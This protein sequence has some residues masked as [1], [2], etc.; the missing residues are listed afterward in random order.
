MGVYN[1]P[2]KLVRQLEDNP[3]VNEF[4]SKHAYSP[5]TMFRFKTSDGVDIDGYMIR[6]F[7]FDST[8]TYPVVLTVYGGP[9]SHD[10]FNQF[11]V[12]GW[13]QW[14]AQN[15][16]I[17]VDINNRGIANY[18]SQFLKIVYKQ[19][20]KWESNDFV[21]AAHYLANAALCRWQ[22]N[23]LWAPVMAA[24]ALHTRC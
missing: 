18:G 16:Y 4:I 9:E 6:P 24:I 15:G 19:L 17:S 1:S 11:A 13:Q 21:E 14:L 8:K 2:G 20:G 10:V 3:E 5:Q 22:P 23:I 7:H 12:D